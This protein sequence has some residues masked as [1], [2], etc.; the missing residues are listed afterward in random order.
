MRRGRHSF[1][2]A[3]RSSRAEVSKKLTKRTERS[4]DGLHLM[5]DEKQDSLPSPRA[6][7]SRRKEWKQRRTSRFQPIKN[8]FWGTTEHQPECVHEG[9]ARVC[10]YR[11]AILQEPANDLFAPQHQSEAPL[12]IHP[13]TPQRDPTISRE[14]FQKPERHNREEDGRQ[15]NQT[16]SSM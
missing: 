3:G 13:S 11:A 8:A 16:A 2:R 15:K 9:G 1:I 5:A 12:Y 6:S 14:T 7:L 4:A 10:C